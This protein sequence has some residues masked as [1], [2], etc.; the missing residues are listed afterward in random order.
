MMFLTG[1]QNICTSRYYLNKKLTIVSVLHVH[2]HPY[3]ECMQK[4]RMN[5]MSG[6]GIPVASRCGFVGPR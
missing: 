2:V 5:P 4:Y 3:K 1:I 6:H